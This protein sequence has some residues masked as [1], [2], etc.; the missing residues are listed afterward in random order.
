MAS[1]ASFSGLAS[2]IQWQ[3]MIDQVMELEAAR[4]VAPLTAQI[5]TQQQRSAAWAN[6]QVV[7]G[8]LSDAAKALRDG[9]AFGTNKVSTTTGAGGRALVGA[10]ATSSAAPGTYKVEVLALAKAE[11]LSG[12][13]VASTTTALGL[14]GEFAVN[15]KKVTVTTTDTLASL[16]DKIN[17]ANAGGAPSRVSASILSTGGGQHRLVLSSDV[18]GSAGID[19]IDGDSG[20]LRSLGIIDETV[21]ANTTATGG[22]QSRAVSGV[23]TA[24]ASA[25]GVT[26][27]APSVIRIGD[28]TIAV[29]LSQ[30]SLASIAAKIQA[31]GI[32]AQT[33]EE[34]VDGRT[35]YRL[36]VEATVGTVPAEAADT[37]ELAAQK[38]AGARTLEVLGFVQ[39]GRGAVRQVVAGEQAWTDGGAAAGGASLLTGLE[40]G[41]AE[42]ALVD[43][44][45]ITIRGTDG[46]GASVLR[47]FAVGAGTTVDDLLTEVNAA[48]AGGRPATATLAADGTIQLT[49]SQG[50]ESK[51]AL[52][53]AVKRGETEGAL[54]GRTT[55]ATAG[56]LR[57]V[58]TGSD[59]VVR[60]DG[61]TVTRGGNNV[62]DVIAGV[63]LSLQ[64]AEPGTEVSV[65]VARDD[66]ATVNAVKA[67]AAA[68]NET[69]AFVTSQTAQGAPLAF[70]GTL[71]S[72]MSKLTGVMLTDLSGLPNGAAYNRATLVGVSLSKT[73]ALE[74][75]ANAL[76]AALQTNFSDVKSLFGAGG[77]ASDAALEYVTAGTATAPGSYA[78]EITAVAERPVLAGSGFGGTYVATGADDRLKVTDASTGK[79]IELALAN[80]ATTADVV[81][82]LNVRFATDGLR[83]SA[84]V[85]GS[86]VTIT[87]TE[88]GAAAAVTV[89]YLPTVG[90]T[91]DPFGLAGTDAGVDVAGTIGGRPA[92]GS[93]RTLTGSAGTTADPNPAEGL[94]VLYTGATVGAAGTLSYTRGVGGLMSQVTEMLTRNG[95]GTIAIQQ[96]SITNSITSLERRVT[97]AEARLALRREAMERQFAAMEAAMSRM[98]SQGNWLTQQISSLPTWSQE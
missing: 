57:A 2:G 79:S 48:F 14:D 18:A 29:D 86:N 80:G 41:G 23:T 30:D 84:A 72:T 77:V 70:N 98:Q 88:Y 74:V 54:L 47:S 28:R 4:R 38:V 68:Y 75:D 42:A 10:T 61:V 35:T 33:V 27:P 31:A 13:V 37:P 81:T 78:V 71:R 11:K 52:S 45:T 66:D 40:I 36:Q 63:S 83:L 55:V 16:R 69:A 20:I 51:L 26:M 76:K 90:G 34:T 22:T 53:L 24:I 97:D 39:P 3:D 50:G 91:P 19:L 8:K 95:D 6:Y 56:R 25:L 5:T 93:G 94:A 65:T 67:F 44:D 85:S 17:G 9:T 87:G 60:V 49:D 15:G 7:L 92:T 64:G 32:P 46:A 21:A 58:A 1:I 12:H 62:S 89:E 43:G 73:G 59:A 82:A 96:D